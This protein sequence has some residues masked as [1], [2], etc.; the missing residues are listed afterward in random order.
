[1]K[2]GWIVQ[3]DTPAN[4]VLHPKNDYVA[5][6]TRDVPRVKII[7][8]G[9]IVQSDSDQTRFTHTVDASTTLENLM[10]LFADNPEGVA[11]EDNGKTIGSVTPQAVVNALASTEAGA[12]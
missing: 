10:P 5:E 2:D 7:T 8:A 1:M 12:R 11:I 9:E 6:F 3:I 4:V